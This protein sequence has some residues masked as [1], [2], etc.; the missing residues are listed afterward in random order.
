MRTKYKQYIRPSLDTEL[1]GETV[2]VGTQ[3][4]LDN[5]MCP[6]ALVV[7]HSHKG[8]QV[9]MN[10]TE[11]IIPVQLDNLWIRNPEGRNGRPLR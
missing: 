4:Q 9:K 10:D 5:N 7:K 8:I 1:L 11:E 3:D 2:L 6:L